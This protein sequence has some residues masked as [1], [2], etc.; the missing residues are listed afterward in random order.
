MVEVSPTTLQ[1]QVNN[2]VA[3]EVNGSQSKQSSNS[4][5]PSSSQLKVTPELIPVQV[6]SLIQSDY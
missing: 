4:V 1:G 5:K 2:Q 3:I 6:S